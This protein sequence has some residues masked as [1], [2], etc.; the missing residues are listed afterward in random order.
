LIYRGA[1]NAGY[2]QVVITVTAPSTAGA[3]LNIVEVNSLTENVN[4]GDNSTQVITNVV[5]VPPHKTESDLAVRKTSPN[6]VIINEDFDYTVVVANLGPD[7]ASNVTVTDI[8]PT[9]VDIVMPLPTGC[10]ETAPMSGTVECAI[11]TLPVGEVTEFVI[12]V[13]PKNLGF[14]INIAQ[15][16]VGE[17]PLEDTVQTGPVPPN[18]TDSLTTEV[19]SPPPLVTF[20]DLFVVK[21]DTPD[22]VVVGEALTYDIFVYNFGP[23]TAQDVILTDILPEMGIDLSMVTAPGC[24][25][26]NNQLVCELG[27]IE[28]GEVAII[29]ITVIPTEVGFILNSAQALL[30]PKLPDGKFQTDIAPGNN[31]DSEVTT[32][33]PIPPPMADL[34]V[35]NTDHPD[36]ITEGQKL[37]YTLFATNYGPDEASDVVLTDTL[38]LEGLDL[39]TVTFEVD[40]PGAGMCVQA[41]A[42]N[43][44]VTC[45][46]SQLVMGESIT[47]QINAE[48][49]LTT[50]G[51][52]S[53]T[54]FSVAEIN[55]SIAEDPHT[56]N[57]VSVASTLIGMIAPSIPIADLSILMTDSPDPVEIGK[58]LKYVIF[59]N[60]AGPDP[61]TGVVVKDQLPPSVELVTVDSDQGSCSG[62]AMNVITCELGDLEAEEITRIKVV[63]K[64]TKIRA[65]LNVPQV[66]GNEYDPVLWNNSSPQVTF[67][68]FRVNDSDG[69]ADL[70]IASLASPSSAVQGRELNYTV[71][72]GNTGSQD[73]EGVTLTSILPLDVSFVSASSNQ[74]TC[75]ESGGIVTCSLGT[76]PDIED[77]KLVVI[78]IVVIPEGV[79]PIV[80]TINIEASQ[81]DPSSFNNNAVAIV[82]VISTTDSSSCLRIKSYIGLLC[83]GKSDFEAVENVRGDRFF[84][85]SLGID[86]VPSSAR[87]RQRLD[88]YAKAR[89]CH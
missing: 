10:T 2:A 66:S 42:D 88:E 47:V 63:V 55:S 82:R 72:V 7:D 18:N 54:I 12:T 56:F 74:G 43:N 69:A 13:N 24:V 78:N 21:T 51:E 50:P 39:D 77:D 62:P 8:L 5:P 83:L 81:E 53:L 15:A 30:T 32:I 35:Q 28:V 23:D 22:P 80:H 59:V 89:C 6:P 41:G 64:P 86:H 16:T 44:I 14:I 87:L 58:L 71:R 75:S 26:G 52:E 4:S 46:F 60:N 76:L 29:P 73:A 25:Q 65:I 37:K 48:V 3:I 20:S 19:I 61:A 57:N 27:D 49:S 68:L 31:T 36:P 84:K 70:F 33:V 38:P 34:F 67:V 17:T 45:E 1:R 79:G 40:P 9:S 85:E 11:E